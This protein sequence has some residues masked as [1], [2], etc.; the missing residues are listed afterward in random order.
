MGHAKAA[1]LSLNI[2]DL[3]VF[4]KVINSSKLVLEPDLMQPLIILGMMNFIDLDEACFDL[5]KSFETF[6]SK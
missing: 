6:W 4:E 5:I 3:E 2:A 1:G